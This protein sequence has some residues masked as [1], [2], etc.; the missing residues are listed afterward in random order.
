MLFLGFGLD[1][2]TSTTFEL[3]LG[4]IWPVSSQIAGTPEGVTGDSRSARCLSKNF[5]I[6][7]GCLER[8]VLI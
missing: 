1:D 7:L 4:R 6:L 3:F 2:V 8:K 5:M